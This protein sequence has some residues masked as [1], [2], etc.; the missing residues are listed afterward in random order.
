M[1]FDI[2]GQKAYVKYGP[3]QNQMGIV[4]RKD[5]SQFTLVIEGDIAIE[6][7]LRD[8]IL[9]DVDFRQFHDWCE[10]NGYMQA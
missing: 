10:K 4:K 6:V 2:I 1:D 3:Y 7:E 5:T 9:V 8:L